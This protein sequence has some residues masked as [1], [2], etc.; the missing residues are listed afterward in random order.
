M[1]NQPVSE[2][3]KARDAERGKQE[4]MNNHTKSY[5]YKNRGLEI[6]MQAMEILSKRL[7]EL[8]ELAVRQHGREKLDT[9]AVMA[10]IGQAIIPD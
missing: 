4:Y 10:Q 7:E 9:L 6:K 8:D 3:E 2:E 1:S 5:V